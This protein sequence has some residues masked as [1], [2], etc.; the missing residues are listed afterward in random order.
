MIRARSTPN[1]EDWRLLSPFLDRALELNEDERRVWISELE[2]E[3]AT[4]LKAMLLEHDMLVSDRFLE[5][6]VVDLPSTTQNCDE[7][8]HLADNA[9]PSEAGEGMA[10]FRGP[11]YRLAFNARFGKVRQNLQM[12]RDHRNCRPVIPLEL[13]APGGRGHRWDGH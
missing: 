1:H 10:Y 8:R 6:T 9:S 12:Q 4:R 5:R 3:I 11:E 13:L 7:L 2:P